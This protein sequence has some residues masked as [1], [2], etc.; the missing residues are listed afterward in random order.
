MRRAPRPKYVRGT[1]RLGTDVYST[2]LAAA[3]LRVSP[4][5]VGKWCS[6]GLLPYYR[7]PGSLDRRIYREDLEAFAAEHG[8]RL[9][10]DRP[11]RVVAVG[12]GVA[13]CERVS[14]VAAGALAG[15]GELAGALVGCPDGL[16]AAAELARALARVCPGLVLGVVLPD[17]RP[18]AD[19]P[20]G[21]FS[22]VYRDAAAAAGFAAGALARTA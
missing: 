18:A 7:L 9:R 17:D 14:A 11:E 5:T 19:V 1:A 4:R 21:V 8:M 16:A 13:G 20:R 15:R 6:K 22:E 12:V 3:R 10:P 2:G